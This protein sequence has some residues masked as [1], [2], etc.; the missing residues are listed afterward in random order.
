MHST[1]R[2]AFRAAVL[3]ALI[4]LIP[5]A[6]QA[7]GAPT[8]P[9]RVVDVRPHDATAFT[10][11]LVRDGRVLLESTG[12]WGPH[13]QVPSSVRRVNSRTGQVIA[14][15]DLP[16]PLFAEG[17]TVLEGVAWQLTWLNGV[18]F[19]LSP[20]SL[21]QSAH[22]PYPHEG[23]GLT[24]QGARLV[25]SDG[26]ARLRWLRTP[27]L[28]VT[29]TVLV[30]D[31]TTLV[32]ALNELEMLNGVIWANV[33]HSDLIALIDPASGRVRGWLDMSPLRSRVGAGADVLNGIARDPVTGHVVVTGKY[34]DRMFVIRLTRRIPTASR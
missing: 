22:V 1:R 20:T 29:R 9:W 13:G 21:A 6:A 27:D 32:A 33:Y 15:R 18:A 5:A 17:L 4:W 25:A 10:E 12:P 16:A 34:W 2:R 7:A 28:R 24:T 23:W 30:R 19:S 11:G 3:F 14:R 26:S 8:I 31:G